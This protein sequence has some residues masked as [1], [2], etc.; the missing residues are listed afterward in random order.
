MH[1]KNALKELAE[2]EDAMVS[3]EEKKATVVLTKDV[4]NE[5]LKEAVEDAGYDVAE[6]KN[7]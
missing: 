4:D 6:I 3:L 2:V 7:I 1:V 5:I